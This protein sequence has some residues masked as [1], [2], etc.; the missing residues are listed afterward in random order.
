MHAINVILLQLHVTEPLEID[1]WTLANIW[2]QSSLESAGLI[3][4]DAIPIIT[5]VR[6]F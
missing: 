1:L 2:G 6:W 5:I 3:F 4:I